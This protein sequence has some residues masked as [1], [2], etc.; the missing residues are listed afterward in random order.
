MVFTLPVLDTVLLYTIYINYKNIYKASVP[1]RIVSLDIAWGWKQQKTQ[2]PLLH[3]LAIGAD[4]IE[5]PFPA[6]ITF[7]T[8]A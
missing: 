4:R 8:F 1:C 5:K 6:V 2:L 7:V 3:E